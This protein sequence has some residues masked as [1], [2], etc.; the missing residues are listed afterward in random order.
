MQGHGIS[1]LQFD[2]FEPEQTRPFL[3]TRSYTLLNEVPL[4]VMYVIG[5]SMRWR[6]DKSVGERLDDCLETIREDF[7]T[8]DNYAKRDG[9]PTVKFWD[10]SWVTWEGEEAS[11]DTRDYILNEFG[12]FE[13]FGN[14]LR[15]ELT[16]DGN[17]PYL[18]GGFSNFGEIYYEE[19]SQSW[20]EEELNLVRSLDAVSNWIEPLPP[21]ESS[22]EK[23]NDIVNS[24]YIGYE[25]LAEEEDLDF[26]PLAYPGYDD[27]DN[28]C[29][30]DEQRYLPRGNEYFE[31]RLR[32]ADEH[33]T[34]DRIDTASFN[35]WGE[36]HQIE[37]GEHRGEEY[38]T[39][40]LE[41]VR[42]FAQGDG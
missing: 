39:E 25:K 33:R 13:E 28:N 32:I 36:G 2:F 31:D 14:H 5:N 11:E 16:V 38:G 20:M 35:D 9:R 4:E 18:I 27:R 8:Q 24:N 17:D 1:R 3:Q 37:P 40:F 26:I 12:G 22:I 7:F 19:G 41:V 10:I 15:S 34:I 30:V 42:E 23:D 6:G 29:W 21:E